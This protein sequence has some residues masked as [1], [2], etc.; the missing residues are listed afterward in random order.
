[1]SSKRFIGID[2]GGTNCRAAL[3]SPQGQV[4]A[5]RRMPTAMDQGLDRFLLRLERVCLDL[6]DC[7]RK[8][9]CWVLAAGMGAPG[10]I[11]EGGLVKVSPNLSQLNGQPLA[12]LLGQRI[13][14]PVTLLNDAN[15]IAWGEARHGAGRQFSSFIALTLGTGVG[16]GLVLDGRL[17][18]GS[19]GSAGEVGHI[20]VEPEG[21]PCGCGSRGCLEQYASATGIVLSVREELVAGRATELAR[22]EGGQMTSDRV[23]QAA[24]RGDSVALSAFV[25]AGRRLGQV[26]AGIAN[27]LNIDGVVFCGGASGSL[28]LFGPAL[29]AELQRRAFASAWQGMQIA[30]GTLGEDAGIVGA[31]DWALRRDAVILS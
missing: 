16:G 17:W 15:A 29:K 3:V 14:L 28:D 30:S 24:R 11:G 19:G 31:A 10:V 1:M 4:T 21:R 23:A 12:G 25:Q 18:E 8:D 27:L 6:I 2:L 5:M 13:S 20:M 22:L 7:A 26:L 9:G